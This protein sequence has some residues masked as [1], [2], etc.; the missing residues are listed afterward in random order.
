MIF[1]LR[2]S[3]TSHGIADIFL[4]YIVITI[5]NLKIKFKFMVKCFQKIDLRNFILFFH[6]T[7]DEVLNKLDI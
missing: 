1:C 6:S 4:I 2:L 5:K 7:F 3:H